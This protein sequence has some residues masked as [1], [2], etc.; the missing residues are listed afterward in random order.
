MAE[1]LS[2]A[3]STNTVP[4]LVGIKFTSRDLVEGGACLKVDGGRYAVFLGA[5]QLMTSAC[6]LGFDSM[7]ATTLNFAPKFRQEILDAYRDPKKVDIDKAREAQ[8]KLTKMVDIITEIGEFIYASVNYDAV[9]T[10]LFLSGD[11]VTSM[12]TAMN[13]LSP[14]DVGA[15]R[16]PLV[17]PS[18]PVINKL[19]ASLK[20]FLEK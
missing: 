12:K 14:I 4:T 6:A 9:S 19:Q 7:I 5:D 16:Q 20:I 13:I 18:Q 3:T 10:I 11:W 17:Q 8:A 2:L 1:F 15:V